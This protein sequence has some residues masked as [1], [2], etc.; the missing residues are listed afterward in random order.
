MRS[1]AAR[2]APVGV[3]LVLAVAAFATAAPAT[4][5][6]GHTSCRDYGLEHAFFARELG[7]LGQFFREASPLND[8]VAL[9]HALFCDP[10]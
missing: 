10:K 4:A 3:A 5:H 8:E 7:G 9:E 2:R 1:H 6:P